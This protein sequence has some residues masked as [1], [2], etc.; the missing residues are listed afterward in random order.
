MTAVVMEE[1]MAGGRLRKGKG[2]CGGGVVWGI[3]PDPST[4]EGGEVPHLF[5]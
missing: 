3:T 1:E 5:F 2:G 4:G